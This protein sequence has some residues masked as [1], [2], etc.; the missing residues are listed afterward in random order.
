MR[1]VLTVGREPRR[2]ASKTVGYFA[3]IF[4]NKKL[5]RLYSNRPAASPKLAPPVALAPPAINLLA[6]SCAVGDVASTSTLLQF[7]SD[8]CI[9]RPA[10]NAKM[11]SFSGRRRRKDGKGRHDSSVQLLASSMY[12]AIAARLSQ[13]QIIISRSLRILTSPLYSGEKKPAYRAA[14]SSS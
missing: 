13:K 7:H 8:S 9:S 11:S 3:V 5:N 1:A 6:C 12:L 2:G 10:K 14:M 4:M